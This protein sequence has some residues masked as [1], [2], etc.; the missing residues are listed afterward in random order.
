MSAGFTIGHGIVHCLHPLQD[1]L[2]DVKSFLGNT[3]EVII[4]NIQ[5]GPDHKKRELVKLLNDELRP[6][7]VQPDQ[8]NW[9]TTMG[10]VWNQRGLFPGKGRV[11]I[12][13]EDFFFPKPGDWN[14]WG[15]AVEVCDLVT[16]LKGK[17]KLSSFVL[18]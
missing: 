15:N 17:V 10:E 6:Y 8:K 3:K 7:L 11:I 5:H 12:L 4:F 1:V 2:N 18:Y 14:D 16:F 9:E 13:Y